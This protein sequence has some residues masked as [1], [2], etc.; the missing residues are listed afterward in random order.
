[1]HL[2]RAGD[3]IAGLQVVAVIRQIADQPAGL[4][5][6][7]NAGCNIPNLQP[8]LPE[9]VEPSSRHIAQIERGSTGSAYARRLLH[10]ILTHLQVFGH[11]FASG[12]I[13]EAGANQSAI[14]SFASTDT[15]AAP[16]QLGAL[17]PNCGEHFLAGWIVNDADFK[18]A[19]DTQPDRDCENGKS[20]DEIRR[21]VERVDDPLKIAAAA[22]TTLLG[23]YRVLGV[24]LVDGLDNNLLS[25]VINL[26]YI[27][28]FGFAA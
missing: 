23:Q 11:P 26:C 22:G 14:Q 15:D 21:A 24:A 28:I 10:D 17:S 25:R 9:T 20:M 27:I 1:M 8:E 16:V 12:P 5:N 3:E 19:F 7:Q 4:P 6:Q 13:R 2:G 18:T